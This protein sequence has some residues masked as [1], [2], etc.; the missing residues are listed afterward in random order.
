MVKPSGEFLESR[1]VA[2]TRPAAAEIAADDF[3]FFPQDLEGPHEVVTGEASIFP[4]RDSFAGDKTIQVDGDVDFVAMPALDP[5]EELGSPR[6]LGE[7][8]EVERV[9]EALA[10]PGINEE[11]VRL[12]RVAISEKPPGKAA[13]EVAATQDADAFDEGIFERAIDPGA[14]RPFRRANV[15]VGMVVKGEDREWFAKLTLPDGAEVMEVAGTRKRVGTK[16][17]GVSGGKGVDPRGR[18]DE[19]ERHGFLAHVDDRQAEAS[20]FGNEIP[21]A[22]GLEK[23]LVG[24]HHHFNGPVIRRCSDRFLRLRRPDNKVVRATRRRQL[25]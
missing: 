9:V 24:G 8:I 4:I 7:R 3:D 17:G 19:A 6:F 5:F 13:L 2:G 20:L 21:G 1:A 15:P 14:A 23:D 18:G 25:N 16:I 11:P 10:F 12:G 22:V